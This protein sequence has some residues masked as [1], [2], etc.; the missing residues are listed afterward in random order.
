VVHSAH[1]SLVISGWRLQEGQGRCQATTTAFDRLLCC[2]TLQC[3]IA[4]WC[5]S[6]FS[7]A[8]GHVYEAVLCELFASHNV[9]SWSAHREL[10]PHQ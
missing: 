4:E 2:E 6:A 8:R 10:A 7:C 1:R 5:V 9:I 3:A